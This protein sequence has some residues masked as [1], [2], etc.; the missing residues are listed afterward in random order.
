MD[1]ITEQETQQR[2][3]DLMA[4]CKIL[5]ANKV[6]P[7]KRVWHL[8]VSLWDNKI[9]ASSDRVFVI[10]AFKFLLRNRTELLLAQ[11]FEM[12]AGSHAC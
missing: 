1:A 10:Y 9:L 7:L 2:S 5:L 12:N 6:F 11:M 4:D 3:H 8:I